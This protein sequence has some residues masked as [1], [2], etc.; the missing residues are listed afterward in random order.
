MIPLLFLAIP[1]PGGDANVT[2]DD[3]RLQEDVPKGLQKVE[4]D[5]DDALFLEFEEQ[6]EEQAP[7]AA[8]FPEASKTASEDEKK[9]RGIKQFDDDAPIWQRWWFYL[10]AGVL[11]LLLGAAAV[12][13]YL[14]LQFEEPQAENKTSTTV[15]STSLA[16]ELE[17]S[18]TAPLIT[19]SKP[20]PSPRST[21]RLEQFNIEYIE[22]G[23]IRLLRCRISIPGVPQDLQSEIQNKLLPIRDGIYL[24]LKNFSNATVTTDENSENLK[25]GLIA[26]INVHLDSGLISELLFDEY[27]VQ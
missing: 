19:G 25:R 5:L 6:E 8:D 13:L 10:L 9:K 3:E 2:L 11:C 15:N 24:H 18:G 22:N 16:P 23:R 4:L 17:Q 14:K 27:V 7:E 20:R 1:S 26:A 12:Y 21:L